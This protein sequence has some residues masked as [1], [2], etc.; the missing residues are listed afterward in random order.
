MGRGGRGSPRPCGAEGGDGVARDGR[1]R[2]RLAARGGNGDGGSGSPWRGQLGGGMGERLRA[3]PRGG[4][5]CGGGR[6]R[7]RL[8]RQLP[9]WL[10][11]GDYRWGPQVPPVGLKF[12]GFSPDFM[13][14]V[15]S[16]E[17][18]TEVHIGIVNPAAQ[19]L[20]PC[21]S[22]ISDSTCPVLLCWP[23]LRILSLPF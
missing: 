13:K 12:T 8:R 6:T 21:L 7:E 22:R 23:Y 19:L 5:G 10:D 17:P 2:Q 20:S 1:E 4:E 18:E 11:L 14:T 9:A 3:C 16:P 15:I